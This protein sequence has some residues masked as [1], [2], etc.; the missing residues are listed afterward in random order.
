MDKKD[1]EW[2]IEK[3]KMN[4]LSEK[5]RKMLAVKAFAYT[6][7]YDSIIYKALKEKLEVENNIEKITIPLDL[8][9]ELRYGENPHQKG[10]KTDVL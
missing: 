5:D 3:V 6:S 4:A 2:F 9:E 1:Y 10:Y 7:Y 8:K